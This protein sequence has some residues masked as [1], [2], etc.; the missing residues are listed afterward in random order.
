MAKVERIATPIAPQG[1]GQAIRQ[2]DSSLSDSTIAVLMAQYGY[3]TGGGGS[4]T[5]NWNIGNV[6]HV[7]GDGYDYFTMTVPEGYGANRQMLPQNFR[8][9]PNLT[10]AV[11]RQLSLLKNGYP[12]AWAAAVRGSVSEFVDGLV[13]NPNRK[14]FTGDP[15]NYKAGMLRYFKKYGGVIAASGSGLLVVIA[16]IGAYAFYKKRAF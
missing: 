14:Y 2:A 4:A 16:G 6:K 8:A 5:W 13:S 3:E 10:T 15:S 12:Q 7:D 1:V 9:Y 11:S